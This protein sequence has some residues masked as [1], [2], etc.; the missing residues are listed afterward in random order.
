MMRKNIHVLVSALLILSGLALLLI[1]L[2][3][4]ITIVVNGERNAIR[5]PALTVASILR[6]TGYPFYA[7]NQ[8]TPASSAWILDHRIIYLNNSA[9]IILWL[10]GERISLTTAERF[11][12]NVLQ[13]YGI[14]IFPSDTLLVDGKNSTANEPFS[15]ASVHTLQF[16]RSALNKT[17]STSA[18]IGATL[19]HQ[20]RPLMGLD[21]STPPED[22]VYTGGEIQTQQVTDSIVLETS[23]IPFE[24]KS[25]QNPEVELDQQV[26]TQTGKYGLAINLTRIRSVDGVEESRKSV[27]STTIRK[28]VDQILSY[29]TMPV[30]KQANVDGV[31]LEYWRAIPM[32]ATSYAPTESGGGGYTASGKPVVQGVAAVI[33]SWYAYM[34][35]QQIYVP[36]YG[37]ATI[38]D[39]GGGIPGKPW[40]DL[41]Y[42]DAHYQS[43][44]GWVTVY[45][46]TPIPPNILFILN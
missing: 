43:W 17:I 36:G 41:G 3:Q 42:D 20:G 5:T 32:Y 8:V 7:G 39:I 14:L 27:N 16:N 2:Y 23:V 12:A 9:S 37:F 28:P 35:G 10:E 30:V 44:S 6:A 18:T 15:A 19:A 45:F 24:Y 34:Q 25:I 31:T 40:I 46:L 22:T 11:P 26:I 21:R 4:P 13:Q 29:G 38:E 33:R 1:Y